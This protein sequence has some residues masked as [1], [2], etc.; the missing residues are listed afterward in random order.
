MRSSHLDPGDPKGDAARSSAAPSIQAFE[1]GR[2]WQEF[3]ECLTD[4]RIGIARD[5]IVDFLHP[6]SLQGKS[7]LDIGCGSGLFSYVAHELGAAPIVSFD[8]DEF[9]V[10]CCRHMHAKA[11][12]PDHWRTLNGSVLDEDFVGSLGQ[13]DIVYA[14]GC[15]H[16]TG[17]MWRAIE[18]A[19]SRV[20][21][22]GLFYIAIYNKV[23]RG[24][25][26]SR[27]WSRVKQ[28]YNKMPRAGK[29][30]ME[31]AYGSCVLLSKALRFKNPLQYVREYKRKRGMSWR[32]DLADWIGGYPYEYATAQELF[33][34][35]R[36]KHPD[37]H[38]INLN[39]ATGLGNHSLLFRRLPPS[40]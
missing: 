19:G 38:L 37:F 25:Q 13:F 31:W 1:F 15:L 22:G 16:H 6:E 5:S 12:K 17:D 3:L 26:T 23:K 11:G 35:I 34:F 18:N 14:W 33:D 30:A 2:N 27:N 40:S 9:S 39:L 7:F 32:R 10:E 24:I 29:T 20:A 36:A 21:P 4:D 28:I 8:V